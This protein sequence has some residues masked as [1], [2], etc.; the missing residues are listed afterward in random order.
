MSRG[1]L[2]FYC[3]IKNYDSD[4]IKK[5]LELFGNEIE[6]IPDKMLSSKYLIKILNIHT[7]STRYSFKIFQDTYMEYFKV[8]LNN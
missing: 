1:N 7:S 5:F 3:Y 4:N 8:I 6:T 2:T